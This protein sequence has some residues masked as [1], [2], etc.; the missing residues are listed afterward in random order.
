MGEAEIVRWEILPALALFRGVP[1][2]GAR[3]QIRLETREAYGAV[4][5]AMLSWRDKSIALFG[6]R[7]EHQDPP[8]S[9]E[10]FEVGAVARVLSLAQRTTCRHWVAE[11]LATGRL[12]AGAYLMTSPF[13]IVRA[14]RIWESSEEQELLDWLVAEIGR[15]LRKLSALVPQCAHVDRAISRIAEISDAS[16]AVGPAMEV[17]RDLPREEQQRAL[18]LPLTSARLNFVRGHLN[19]RVARLDPRQHQLWA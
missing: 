19:D 2:P 10:L 8:R 6:V 15:S 9:A 5:E 12:R 11:I 1:F 18:E 17:L 3:C 4:Q 7:A 13:R 16:E 14:E